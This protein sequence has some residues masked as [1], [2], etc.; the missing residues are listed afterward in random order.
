MKVKDTDIHHHLR[1]RMLQ[2]GI[3]KEEIEITINKGWGAEDAKE[4]TIGKTFIFPYNNYWE[5]RYYEEKEVA[6]YYKMKEE[7]MVLLTAKAR[8]GKNFKKGGQ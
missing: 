1:V 3:T 5:D 4:G 7:K 2:R 6:V 8:Y